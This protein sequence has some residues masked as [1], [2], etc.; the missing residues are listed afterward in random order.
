MTDDPGWE[1]ET[2]KVDAQF[3]KNQLGD[4]LEQYTFLIA[5]PPAMAEGVE[6]ALEEAGVNAANVFVERYS[7]Y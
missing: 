1:G 2:R 6:Q 7:G 3:I 4:E 5:G